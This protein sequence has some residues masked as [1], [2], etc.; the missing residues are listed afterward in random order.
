MTTKP[1]GKKVER[2][3]RLRWIPLD[4]M[5]VSPLAQRELNSARVDKIA[6]EMELEQ[7]GNL[8]VNLRD[9]HYYIIDGQHRVE[10]YKKWCGDGNWEG[11]SMQCWTYEGLSE[12]EEAEVFLK[13]ND[14]LPVVTFEKFRVGVRAGRPEETDIDRIVR[15]QK[16]RVSREYGNGAIRA[17]ATLRK[18]Y[19]FGPSTLGRTLRLIRDTY[20]DAGLEAPVIEGVGLLCQRYNGDLDETVAQ[21]RLSSV[22]GGVSG[23][24]QSAERLR[25]QTGNP[26]AHCVA[27]AAVE[28]YNRGRGGPK[29]LQ[30]WWRED[31][32]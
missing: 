21:Q 2:E 26:R 5:K 27:A 10:A 30:P 18:V 15:A 14:T 13:L 22:H 4:D 31:G 17:V 32:K 6:S 24:M 11:Q 25:L 16:L 20:G 12:E 19:R 3:A 23:L 8:T 28:I 29:K 7:L 9:E 1:T